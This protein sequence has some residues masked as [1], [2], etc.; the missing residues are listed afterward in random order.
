MQRAII[1]VTVV[2]VSS[3][4]AQ[5]IFD[6]P[7]TT[8]TE[9]Y[10]PSPFTDA[11]GDVVRIHNISDRHLSLRYVGIEEAWGYFWVTSANND[12]PMGGAVVGAPNYVM[13]FDS[14][15]GLYLQKFDQLSTYAAAPF[16]IPPASPWGGRDLAADESSGYLYMGMEFG[17]LERYT[18]DPDALPNGALTF[19]ASCPIFAPMLAY[20]IRGLT[21]MPSG[22]LLIADFSNPLFIVADTLLP[23]GGLWACVPQPPGYPKRVE[24]T[25]KNGA[26]AVVYGLAYDDVTDTYWAWVQEGPAMNQRVT[27]VEFR[28]VNDVI[29]R[30]GREFLG[31]DLGMAVAN[32]AGGADIVCDASGRRQLI[33]LHQ[34]TPDTIVIYDL[35]AY[36]S[37]PCYAD[38]D[39]ST[40]FGVLDIFDFL[41]FGNA[42]A[43][44]CR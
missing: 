18:W 36:C 30:T 25:L 15:T 35:D 23:M 29:V 4:W 19:D 8:P 32:I 7:T 6:A 41:C 38:C 1:L 28:M 2:C 26:P 44:G 12:G 33:A 34:A 20:T 27:G 39:H 14:R 3:S 10:L 42:F 9:P 24:N 37:R 5:S 22:D 21:K 13:Q 16:P 17:F 40:G 31:S 11:L 43:Q